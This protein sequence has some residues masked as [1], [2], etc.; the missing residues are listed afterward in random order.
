MSRQNKIKN[1]VSKITSAIYELSEMNNS[2]IIDAKVYLKS[3]LHKLGISEKKLVTRKENNEK[4]LSA[5]NQRQINN[6]QI[7]VSVAIKTID[8][9]ISEQ[10][11]ILADLEKIE[12]TPENSENLHD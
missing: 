6:G 8:Q 1:A 7:N 9:M 12:Q 3:A 11:K 4:E 10:Q 5:F 2:E